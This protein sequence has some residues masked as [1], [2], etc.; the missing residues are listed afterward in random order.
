[1]GHFY[2]EHSMRATP[3]GE[4]AQRHRSAAGHGQEH[5][6]ENHTQS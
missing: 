6:S 5:S 2:E 4:I 3:E 1:M